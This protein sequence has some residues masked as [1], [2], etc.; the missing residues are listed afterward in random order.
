MPLHKRIIPD[1]SVFFLSILSGALIG[2]LVLRTRSAILLV[3]GYR[4]KAPIIFP[5]L[6]EFLLC[7]IFLC[8]GEDRGLVDF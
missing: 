1:I 2:S 6:G 7:V 4:T 5:F 3:D 8:S